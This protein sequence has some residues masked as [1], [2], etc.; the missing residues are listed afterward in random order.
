MMFK[1]MITPDDSL[2]MQENK[3]SSYISTKAPKVVKV[4]SKPTAKPMTTQVP[5]KTA[6]PTP[7]PFKFTA[8]RSGSPPLFPTSAVSL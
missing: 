4:T 7:T 5:K 8:A 2:K 6:V 3:Q 1:F